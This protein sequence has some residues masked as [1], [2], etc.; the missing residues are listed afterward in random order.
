M[1]IC[2]ALTVPC[3]CFWAWLADRLLGARKGD[4][5]VGSHRVICQIEDACLVVLCF[6]LLSAARRMTERMPMGLDPVCMRVIATTV[7]D[8]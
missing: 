5:R 1:L 6:G 4:Q 3:W 8:P 2:C 7:S